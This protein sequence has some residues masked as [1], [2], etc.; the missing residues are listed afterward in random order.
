[1]LR[2]SGGGKEEDGERGAKRTAHGVILLPIV[3]WRIRFGGYNTQSDKY[4]T[5]KPASKSHL[6]SRSEKIDGRD[7]GGRK[8]LP[9]CGITIPVN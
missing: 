1:L 2:G 9:H 7:A 6:F 8:F 3:I 4:I 5:E